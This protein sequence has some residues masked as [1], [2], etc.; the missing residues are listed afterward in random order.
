MQNI[1]HQERSECSRPASHELQNAKNLDL[2]DLP[3]AVLNSARE[4]IREYMNQYYNC[5]DP[6]ESAARKA[7]LRVSEE[8]RE[9]E[10]VANQMARKS[11][12]MQR[13]E[14]P[15]VQHDTTLGRIPALS[16]LGPSIEPVSSLDRLGPLESPQD[17]NS[18]LSAPPPQKKKPG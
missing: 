11:L 8:Q 17:A 2:A 18:P 10:E 1:I 4:E 6:T 3:T 15:E 7:R 5:L 13:M 12:E 14:L 16:R 9:I